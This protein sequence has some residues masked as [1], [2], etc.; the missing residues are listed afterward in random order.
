MQG[1]IDKL[2]ELKIPR[3][4]WYTNRMEQSP[5]PA[6]EFTESRPT[7]V[8]SLSEELSTVRASFFFSQGL[9]QLQRNF[10]AIQH[11][12]HPEQRVDPLHDRAILA[13]LKQ[14]TTSLATVGL[15][16]E[17]DQE[18]YLMGFNPKIALVVM[19]KRLNDERGCMFHKNGKN[20]E[21]N[22]QRARLRLYRETIGLM[23]ARDVKFLAID[24]GRE[25]NHGGIIP[26]TDLEDP[27]LSHF[28]EYIVNANSS[29]IP[30]VNEITKPLSEFYH[31]RKPN[32][33]LTSEIELGL[34]NEEIA[35]MSFQE[36]ASMREEKFKE[37][38]ES[39]NVHHSDKAVTIPI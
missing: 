39:Y 16:M 21:E 14:Y 11:I 10:F 28:C 32:I 12:L 13:H 5:A 19:R 27:F 35:K 38:V 23:I 31:G 22:N 26:K 18:E 30:A 25:R 4:V 33:A 9:G 34:P 8:V 37:M 2:L 7:R 24:K 20:A 6:P 17:L 15:H 1:G 29:P 36:C 3:A